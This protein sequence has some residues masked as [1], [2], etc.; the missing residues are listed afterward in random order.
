MFPMRIAAVLGLM[1]GFCA[2]CLGIE[3]VLPSLPPDLVLLGFLLCVA[4]LA[5]EVF[6][7]VK[8]LLRRF[9]R[10]WKRRQ[11]DRER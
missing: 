4:Y 2:A 1:L 3:L 8:A 10:W 9:K 6:E 11:K 5:T 7:G